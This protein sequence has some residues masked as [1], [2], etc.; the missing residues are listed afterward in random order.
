MRARRVDKNQQEIV[1]ALIAIGC[2]VADTS[3][4]GEGFPD[5]VVG[6]RGQNYLIEI[7]DGNKSP[8]RRALTPAQETFHNNWRGRVVIVKNADEAIQEVTEHFKAKLKALK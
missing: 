4:S 8:S 6:Y 5:L 2:T 1:K 7:K 3:R